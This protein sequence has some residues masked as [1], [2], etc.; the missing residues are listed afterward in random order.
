VNRERCGFTGKLM[1]PTREAALGAL[2]GYARALGSRKVTKRCVF[3]GSF[4][5]TKGTRG[6]P[7]KAR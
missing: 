5:L 2:A 6:R 4:H 3:C 7:G 1:F